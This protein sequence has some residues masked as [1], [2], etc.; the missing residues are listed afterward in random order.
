MKSWLAVALMV[1][2]CGSYQPGSPESDGGLQ[3]DGVGGGAASGGG[4]GLD[5][6]GGGSTSQT[7][8]SGGP[9]SV[10]AGLVLAPSRWPASA[11]RITH[12]VDRDLAK[13]LET[14][15]L[16]GACAAVRAG[17]TDAATRV[18]CGKWMFFYET[19]GTVGV[20]APLLD[21]LQKHYG[22]S[23]Y[24][25]GFE[26]LG[27]V[28]DPAS[29][30]GMP[31]GLAPTTGKVGTV[32][33]KAFT[34]ASCHFGKMRD[35]RY[36][37]GYANELLDYGRFISSLGAPLNLS[38]NEND[39]NV[40]EQF[41]TQ[42]GP[43]VAAKKTDPFYLADLA[44]TGLTLTGA[45]DAGMISLEEQER[46]L[47]LQPGTMDFLTRPLVD[48]GVWTVSRLLSLWNLPDDN[49][50]RQA[51]MKHELLSWNGG[52][53]TLE[54]FLEGFVVIG[55]GK[56]DWPPERLAPLAE[57]VRTLRTPDLETPVNAAQVKAG[58]ELF[59]SKQCLTC[60]NGPSGESNRPYTF[61]EVGTDRAYAGIYN[62]GPD[63]KPCCGLGGEAS[64][65]THGVKAPRMAGMAWQLRLLH[66]GSLNSLEELFCLTP[67]PMVMVPAQTAVGH[68]MT[69]EGL[70]TDEKWALVTYLRSL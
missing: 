55:V 4:S 34:C 26:R 18:R 66:N 56:S 41:R 37:V 69:C 49:Q 13:V 61:D 36:A 15:S 17:A 46:F 42:L 23:Y 45:G 12:D 14:S 8:G 28:A 67:R 48:D 25:R 50:R 20:P 64:N 9:R 47:G 31:L 33:T 51:G 22:D 65:V 38:I 52:V 2:G 53:A 30:T 27:F 39:P 16:S 58:A 70:T 1:V 62:P 40:P 60:H 44:I 54:N 24:G 11:S 29:R 5:A 68:Q 43:L 7:G 19:F 63:G 57:Y 10:D 6:T 35:G 59:V 3:S 21:F 32:E